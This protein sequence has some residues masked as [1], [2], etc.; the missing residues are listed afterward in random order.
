M[1]L[2]AGAPGAVRASYFDNEGHVLQYAARA[3][4]S[5]A[6]AEFVTDE[7][8]GTPQFR[9]SYRLNPDGTLNTT[10]EIAPPGSGF[11]T[12]LEGTARRR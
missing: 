8:P 2:F 10:F 7:A 12:Y 4:G 6:R 11:R 3:E 1:V 9:L 5:P